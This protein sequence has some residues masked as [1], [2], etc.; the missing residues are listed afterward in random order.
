MLDTGK[1]AEDELQQ[2]EDFIPQKLGF[3]LRETAKI[4]GRSPKWARMKAESGKLRTVWLDG[5][6]IVPRP[7]IFSAVAKGMSK[8][9][10]ALEESDRRPGIHDQTTLM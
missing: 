7:V 8:R 6:R 9:P 5:Q 4:L 1:R 2:I 3:T 10:P